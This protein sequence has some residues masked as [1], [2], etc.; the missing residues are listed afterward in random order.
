MRSAE[1]KGRTRLRVLLRRR[2]AAPRRP[3]ARSIRVVLKFTQKTTPTMEPNSRV[4]ERS[5]NTVEDRIAA[6]EREL[7]ELS[8]D[9]EDDDQAQ[10]HGKRAAPAATSSA[11][12]KKSKSS[13]TA[14]YSSMASSSTA[15][16]GLRCDICNISV[17]SEELM[18][19]HMHGKKH[20]QAE[21]AKLAREEGRYCGAC[22]LVF[23]GPEQLKEHSK[24]KRH[25]ERARAVSSARPQG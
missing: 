11:N 8:S 7:A 17:T 10:Q 21:K 23:T 22:A 9:D 14:T 6:L 15:P 25:R 4:V 2:Q 12:S 13:S 19:E 5:L 1:L 3:S 20:K 18:R 16:L 24:G